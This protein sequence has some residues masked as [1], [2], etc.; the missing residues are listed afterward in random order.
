MPG[1]DCVPLCLFSTAPSV[2]DFTIAI[3]QLFILWQSLWQI[4]L[5][6]DLL[7]S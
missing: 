1:H 5:S 7:Y 3:N 4:Y 2:N 6:D